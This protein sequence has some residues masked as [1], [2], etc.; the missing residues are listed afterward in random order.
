VAHVASR[1]AALDGSPVLGMAIMRGIMGMDFH[2]GL[3]PET[4]LLNLHLA[5]PAHGE[6]ARP[7]CLLAEPRAV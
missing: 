3:K 6:A 5:Q 1:W 4:V 2:F 7:A